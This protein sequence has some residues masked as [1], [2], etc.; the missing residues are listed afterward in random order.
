MTSNLSRIPSQTVFGKG[1]ATE[2][3]FIFFDVC[4]SKN[5]DLTFSGQIIAVVHNLAVR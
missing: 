2:F 4:C 3:C 1:T 5:Y